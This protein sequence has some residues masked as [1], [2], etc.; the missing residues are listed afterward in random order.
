MH[1]LTPPGRHSR[2]VER[3]SSPLRFWYTRSATHRCASPQTLQ[4]SRSGQSVGNEWQPL[5]FFSRKLSGAQTRYSAYDRELLA[6]Y[7]AARHFI[8]AIE[9]RFV[10]LRTDH[11]PLLFMF[12][13][14]AEKLID[15]QARHIAFLS[16]YFHEVEHISGELN[17]VP[18]AL[19]RLELAP[20]DDGLPDLDQWATDQASDTDLQDI[21]TGKTKSSLELDARQTAN[22]P[23]YFDVAQNR[24]RLFVPLRQRRAVFNAL[25]RQAHG[26]GTS[27]AA[28]IAQRFV[29]PGM[30]REIQR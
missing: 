2:P 9:G 18:D 5:G 29:W 14:K 20:L 30:N 17:V 8:H 4:I 10:T 27:T 28:L 15:R 12:S 6:A 25:H 16:Q 22:G 1:G 24:S 21:L 7:L 3:H 19:S 23:V 26:G 13:Q 11:R